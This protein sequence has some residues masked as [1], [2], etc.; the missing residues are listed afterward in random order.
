MRIPVGKRRQPQSL[1]QARKPLLHL[2]PRHIPQLRAQPNIR[3]HG[4]PGQHIAGL[5]HHANIRHRRG[6]RLSAQQN[7]PAIGWHQSRHHP[8]QRTLA[9]SARPQDRDELALANL[10]RYIVERAECLR[11]TPRGKALTDLFDGNQR[12]RRFVAMQRMNLCAGC[13][14]A[15][16]NTQLVD[17]CHQT[18]TPLHH[19]PRETS[20]TAQ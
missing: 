2:R 16:H 15:L 9:A 4:Q 13:R 19:T 20:S 17:Q 11:A 5:K 6:N 14:G 12:R 8:Q 18:V 1:K 7:L 3:P 10:H